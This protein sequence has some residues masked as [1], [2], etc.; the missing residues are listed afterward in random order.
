MEVK[1]RFIYWIV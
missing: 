1:S